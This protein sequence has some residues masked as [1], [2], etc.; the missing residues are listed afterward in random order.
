[1]CLNGLNRPYASRR[2]KRPRGLCVGCSG[3]SRSL[4]ISTRRDSHGSVS[5]LSWTWISSIE[6]SPGRLFSW[7]ITR[8]R[9]AAVPRALCWRPSVAC[10]GVSSSPMHSPDVATLHRA[11]CWRPSV[12]LPV[13]AFIPLQCTHPLSN[14]CLHHHFCGNSRPL[15]TASARARRRACA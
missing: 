1:M 6:I 14:A 7:E 9:G 3:R 12:G 10:G 4:R 13:A 11:P 15:Q 2:C 8:R 5:S